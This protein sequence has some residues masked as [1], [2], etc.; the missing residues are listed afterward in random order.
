MVRSGRLAFGTAT[1]EESLSHA[2]AVLHQRG[3]RSVFSAQHRL[4]GR[5]AKRCNQ[6]HAD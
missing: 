5:S 3:Y 4:R 2:G 1:V 6:P